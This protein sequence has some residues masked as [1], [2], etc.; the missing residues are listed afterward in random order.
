M[1]RTN[2]N[3]IKCF[4]RAVDLNFILN[5]IRLL[6]SSSTREGCPWW[7]AGNNNMQSWYRSKN[8]QIDQYSK[9]QS[10]LNWTSRTSCRAVLCPCWANRHWT[11]QGDCWAVSKSGR[12]WEQSQFLRWNNW[13]NNCA[14]PF[15]CIES[16]QYWGGI[17][18]NT[19]FEQST[20]LLI[21]TF[22]I[23]CCVDTFL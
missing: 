4:N 2:E 14:P 18:N 8:S 9:W 11:N 1:G 13:N 15:C 5:L 19:I 17:K 21:R 16:P 3:S 6:I 7:P 22:I 23:D 10:P 20:F 12:L